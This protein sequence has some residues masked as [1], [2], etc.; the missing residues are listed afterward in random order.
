MSHGGPGGRPP[1]PRRF[2]ADS[3]QGLA[4]NH[5]YLILLLQRAFGHGAR[6]G[7]AVGAN[8]CRF[9]AA[10]CQKNSCRWRGLVDSDIQLSFDDS[11]CSSRHP[12][13]VPE[14]THAMTASWAGDGACPIHWSLCPMRQPRPRLVRRP[15]WHRELWWPRDTVG[16]GLAG[17]S[18]RSQAQRV[19][20]RSKCWVLSQ[21]SVFES[22]R[23]VKLRRSGPVEGLRAI[24]VDVSDPTGRQHHSR[25]WCAGAGR[26]R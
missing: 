22:G 4:R 20:L 11:R 3:A 21:S 1:S 9:R 26:P 15:R 18:C 2:S 23:S 8:V 17:R 6:N 12:E 16:R 10:A 25:F 19:A 7:T 24:R 5:G 14:P 13:A